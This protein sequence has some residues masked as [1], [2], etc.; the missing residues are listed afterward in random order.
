M[1][2]SKLQTQPEMQIPETGGWRDY[3]PGIGSKGGCWF[4]RSDFTLLV[5]A[6]V[7]DERKGKFG[8]VRP[9]DFAGAQTKRDPRS[10]AMG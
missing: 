7:A 4:D 9:S 10:E 6:K 2:F 5:F 8:K 1:V 3:A